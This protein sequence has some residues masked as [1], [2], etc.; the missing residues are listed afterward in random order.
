MT[1]VPETFVF[2]TATGGGAWNLWPRQ[3]AKVSGRLACDLRVDFWDRRDE[4]RDLSA[5]WQ[6]GT[7][8]LIQ[9]VA[10]GG[11]GKTRLAFEWMEDLREQGYSGCRQAFVWSFSRQGDLPDALPPEGNSQS[12]LE[13]FAN[14]LGD[15]AA[16][17]DDG[18]T[19]T[20]NERKDPYT[21]GQKIGQAF[22]RIGGGLVL[23]GLE[24]LQWPPTDTSYGSKVRDLGVRGLVD[25]LLTSPEA[26]GDRPKRLLIIT[27]RQRVPDLER[28]EADP[29]ELREWVPGDGAALFRAVRVAHLP[30]A[31][32]H[33]SSAGSQGEE[34]EALEDIASRYC[35][36]H[37]LTL[38]LLATYVLTRYGGDLTRWRDQ[39]AAAVRRRQPVRPSPADYG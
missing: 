30:A 11:I 32:L 16:F 39:G 35:G 7:R 25:G 38:I 20:D 22:D 37:T 23:D 15:R 6:D 27:T 17:G 5:A 3:R 21:L 9:I 4:L 28:W 26:G 31:R 1:Q 24:V 8:A 2:G 36:G 19:L 34:R 12:F 13:A 29:I 18:L 14:H 33:F 10:S